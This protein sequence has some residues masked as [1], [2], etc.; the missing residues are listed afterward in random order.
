MFQNKNCPLALFILPSFAERCL[1]AMP[2]QLAGY[3]LTALRSVLYS[4]LD[5][6]VALYLSAVISGSKFVTIPLQMLPK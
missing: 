4:Y 3:I 1:A 2:S 5:A 6:F